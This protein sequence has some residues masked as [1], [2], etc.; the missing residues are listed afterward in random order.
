M[1]FAMML[2]LTHG[3]SGWWCRLGCRARSFLLRVHLIIFK[4]GVR[5]RDPPDAEI[6]KSVISRDEWYLRVG[7][8]LVGIGRMPSA[9][10][11]EITKLVVSRV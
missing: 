9:S 7:L 1:L 3:H 4:S 2:G 6:T 5:G 8:S 10:A 11:G